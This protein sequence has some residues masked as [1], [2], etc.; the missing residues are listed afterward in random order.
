MSVYLQFTTG[1]GSAGKRTC[2]YG[3][4]QKVHHRF[5]PNPNAKIESRIYGGWRVQMAPNMYIRRDALQL[6]KQCKR[7][8]ATFTTWRN[9]K[10]RCTQLGPEHLLMFRDR[11]VGH[12]SL[13]AQ[14][15]CF[16]IYGF[17][18]YIWNN[19]VDY[20]SSEHICNYIER[21]HVIPLLK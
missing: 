21:N 15:A 8:H 2:I 5:I 17:C 9:P 13:L 6:Q 18:Q 4:K 10:K 20:V 1:L 7:Q 16:T 3:N 12:L 14:L 11:K 19:Y